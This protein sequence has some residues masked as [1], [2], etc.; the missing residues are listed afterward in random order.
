[1]I[2]IYSQA[3]KEEP[4]HGSSFRISALLPRNL[5]AG[6]AEKPCLAINIFATVALP[7]TL[8]VLGIFIR[9][10][11]DTHHNTAFPNIFVINFR[12]VFGNASAHW[13]ADDPTSQTTCAGP[14]ERRR[15]WYR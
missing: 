12:P 9:A 15:N 1:V 8:E 13:R 14:R 3:M 7:F 10:G 6:F 2:Q 4:D 5:I 11:G